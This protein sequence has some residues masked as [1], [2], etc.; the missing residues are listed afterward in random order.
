MD[1]FYNSMGQILENFTDTKACKISDNCTN[2]KLIEKKSKDFN[3]IC[4]KKLQY[5]KRIKINKKKIDNFL[6]LLEIN[7]I[8]EFNDKHNKLKSEILNVKNKIYDEKE[9]LKLGN[10]SEKELK[11][12]KDFRI[13]IDDLD[14][15]K[16]IIED[17]MI[18]FDI[19]DEE[20]D[21]KNLSSKNLKNRFNKFKIEYQSKLDKLIN[22]NT[23]KLKNAGSKDSNSQNFAI[24][25][26]MSD[27]I[28]IKKNKT[29]EMIKDIENIDLKI[30]E[31]DKVLKVK[32]N[33]LDKMNSEYTKIDED[34]DRNCIEKICPKDYSLNVKFCLVF[35]IIMMIYITLNKIK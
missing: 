31:M 25:R 17:L 1:L 9:K 15:C 11:D 14:K 21:I 13:K 8:E 6:N 34:R 24:K 18:N 23:T 22:E 28:K 20:V 19:K 26:H 5:N 10:I 27:K 35:Q 32:S 3:K 7:S 12:I 16:I 29:N 2:D 4:N 30:L 33:D